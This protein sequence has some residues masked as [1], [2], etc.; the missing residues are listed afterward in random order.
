MMT[1]MP[2]Q[3]GRGLRRVAEA[4]NSSSLPCPPCDK[5]TNNKGDNH[6][7]NAAITA[8]AVIPPSPPPA[9]P[10]CLEE[11]KLTPMTIRKRKKGSWVQFAA[12]IT[13]IPNNKT[14][15]ARNG[16]WFQR[17]RQ[18]QEESSSSLWYSRHDI[19]TF[20][21]AYE[22]AKQDLPKPHVTATRSKA[23]T[24][25]STAAAAA[26]AAAASSWTKTLTRVYSIF[27]EAKSPD[28]ILQKLAQLQ[29][30]SLPLSL[31]QQ[32][33]HGQYTGLE[34]TLPLVAVDAAIRRQELY[35]LVV[36]QAT[37]SRNATTTATSKSKSNN[38]HSALMAK[39]CRRISRPCKLYARHVADVAM[40]PQQQQQH[41]QHSS[42]T[43]TAGTTK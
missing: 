16:S 28:E 21:L 2:L 20:A 33:Q 15:T 37:T 36:W 43:I 13:V 42:T 18:R 35:R 26:A 29:E 5:E 9:A 24:S 11:T 30:S 39:A 38:S 40:T 10:T 22:V 3:R 34:R 4:N 1:R 31:K 23:P 17:H 32:E 6:N 12:Q 19:Q 27:C 14:T 8:A 41:Q 25:T 7:E